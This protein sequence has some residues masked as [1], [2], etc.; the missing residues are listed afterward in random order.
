MSDSRYPGYGRPEYPAYESEPEQPNPR[1]RPDQRG[2]PGSG[3][4]S[5]PPP[6]RQPASAPPNYGP[7]AS[8][9]PGYGPPAAPPPGYGPAAGT[10]GYPPRDGRRGYPQQRQGYGQPAH[11]DQQGYGQPGYPGQRGYAQQRPPQQAYG[12]AP[13][14]G[15]EGFD[16]PGY[17][18]PGYRDPYR[19]A[20]SARSQ[21]DDFDDE[22]T[23]NPLATAGLVFGILGNA[24]LLGWIL[25]GIGLARAGRRGGTGRGK[26]ITGLVLSTVWAIAVPLAYPI[27]KSAT[28]TA[29][30]RL[31]PGCVDM[32]NYM[33]G[34]DFTA[35]SAELDKKAPDTKV[36]L[37][38]L[39]G[40]VTSLRA[41]AKKSNR[42][43]ATVAINTLADDFQV[44][45]TAGTSA[46][47][48]PKD[49]DKKIDTDVDAAS[50]ACGQ[51]VGDSGSG[52]P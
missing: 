40:T 51:P 23:P 47:E 49:I 10:A 28:H 44:L 48:P 15:P 36:V 20:P 46:K 7:P 3:Q 5:Y 8:A 4:P 17:G 12:Q 41:A 50:A 22:P 37:S 24:C 2:W 29:A 33:S 43:D 45:V 32:V 52:S 42:A 35:L 16:G 31:N 27:V 39:Q 13:Y 6:G 9:P 18:R 11:P 1:N 38:G 26:A 14:R 19:S 25:S 34:P 30:Q 21:P